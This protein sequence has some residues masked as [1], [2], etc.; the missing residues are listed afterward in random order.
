MANEAMIRENEPIAIY[1]LREFPVV[2]RTR[3]LVTRAFRPLIEA[4][5]ENGRRLGARD[6]TLLPLNGTKFQTSPFTR[7]A[8]FK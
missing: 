3:W 6:V 5:K 1:I 8:T 2:P 7:D 4:R